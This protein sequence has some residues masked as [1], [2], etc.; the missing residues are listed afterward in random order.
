MS[1][2]VHHRAISALLL[3]AG[4]GVSQAAWGMTCAVESSGELT[5]AWRGAVAALERSIN[6]DPREL[7]CARVHVDVLPAGARVT[8]TTADG[9]SAVRALGEASELSPTVK[10]LAA[11]PP[12]PVMAE[13][14]PNTPVVEPPT[15]VTPVMIELPPVTPEL[16]LNTVVIPA[17]TA[18]GPFQAE[19]AATSRDQGPVVVTIVS[20]AGAAPKTTYGAL[21][22]MRVGA[23]GLVTPTIEA[24]GA[25]TF[26][27]WQ[28]GV[29]GRFEAFYR[30]VLDTDAQ[31]RSRVGAGGVTFGQYVGSGQVGVAYGGMLLVTY[32]HEDRSV[33]GEP[34][35]AH[36]DGRFGVYTGLVFP[37]HSSVRAR[38]NL[39]ADFLPAPAI[40]RSRE[41]TPLTP[42]WAVALAFGVE[43]GQ[44]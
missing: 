19:L 26:D 39:T 41:G 42:W 37:R 38:V 29:L 40:E 33:K 15:E 23:A 36:V 1:S 8:F 5:A 44:P 27:Q 4:L 16:T 13:L 12:A 3:L 6:E 9:R 32:I 11:T 18:S 10:A 34:S 17:P 43:I 28:V 25:L 21:G 7:D 35:D 30:N 20:P 2:L 31:P 14:A 22:G 24:F